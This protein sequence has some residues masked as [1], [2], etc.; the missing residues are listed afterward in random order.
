MTNY[1]FVLARGGSK[2]LKQKN[3]RNIQGCSLVKRALLTCVESKIG[4]TILSSDSPEIL[5][6][7]RDIPDTILHRRRPEH[8]EDTTSSEESILGA[9]TDLG[10]EKK[11]G[12]DDWGIL[13]QPTFPF[14]LSDDLKRLDNM[15][16]DDRHDALFSANIVEDYFIWK[17][18]EDGLVSWT[19]DYKSRSRRQDLIPWIYENGGLYAFRLQ[20]FISKKV[21]MFGRIG[22]L[23]MENWQHLE[24]D[25]E[26]DLRVCSA[27]FKEFMK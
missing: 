11:I 15:M 18:A 17:Q 26:V 5:S 8:A 19:Y 12:P 4:I 2:G 20:K 23:E 7:G 9:I 6:E 27:I 16:R 13:V 14:L 22:Y 3:L 24:I 21:R 10:L 1:L 25:D